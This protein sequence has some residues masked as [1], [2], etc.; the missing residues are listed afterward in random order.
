MP[1]IPAVPEPEAT[2]AAPPPARVGPAPVIGPNDLP[3][4]V[5]TVETP[6]AP[7]PVPAMPPPALAAAVPEPKRL[8]QA[9][10]VAAFELPDPPQ[11]GPEQRARL[12]QVAAAYRGNPG[13]VKIIGFA[14]PAP[15]GPEQLASFRA[16]LDRAQFVASALVE[17]G[18]PRGKI[19]AEASPAAAAAA[20]RVEV[21]LAP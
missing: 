13:T 20:G 9:A 21:R 4:A 19:Q 2:R 14:A 18:V 7:P 17:A 10:P 3:A 8:S 6:A 16:A 15:A 11:L 5:T 1:T 12:G